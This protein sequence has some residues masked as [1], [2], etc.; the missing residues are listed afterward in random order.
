M[1]L[2]LSWVWER[3]E[4]GVVVSK[5]G[6]VGGFISEVVVDRGNRRVAAV[7]TNTRTISANDLAEKM[8]P[9]EISDPT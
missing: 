6:Q 2:G 8:I 4:S 3:Q 7:I 9:I 1:D 5:T